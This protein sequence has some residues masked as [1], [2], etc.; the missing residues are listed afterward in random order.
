MA[1]SPLHSASVHI[2]EYVGVP[3]P[4]PLVREEKQVARDFLSPSKLV[5][6]ASVGRYGR[7]GNAIYKHRPTSRAHRC[8]L[9]KELSGC[10]VLSQVH[11]LE[12][13]LNTSES[14]LGN[15]G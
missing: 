3:N 9:Q 2:T 12:L 5:R 14:S 1:K 7:A 4:Q 15:F 10:N 13:E 6:A 8:L 11:R